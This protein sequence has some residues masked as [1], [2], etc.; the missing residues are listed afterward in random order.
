MNSLMRDR[1]DTVAAQYGLNPNI[2]A[3]LV[4]KEN[5]YDDMQNAAIFLSDMYKATGNYR[6]AL[7][8]YHVGLE[9]SQSGTFVE[10]MKANKFAKEVFKA[11]GAS[12]MDFAM[13]QRPE[14]VN[15][16][17]LGNEKPGILGS[18]VEYMSGGA[19]NVAVVVMGG[20]LLFLAIWNTVKTAP[21]ILEK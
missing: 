17:T 15:Q 19:V 6:D 1:I 9:P 13:A 21:V 11:A 14:L 10:R 12:D 7:A 20:A 4:E 3:A 2:F 8:A 5:N 18:I 16:A